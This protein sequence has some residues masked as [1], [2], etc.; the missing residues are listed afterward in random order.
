MLNAEL[1]VFRI[2]KLGTGRKFRL[3]GSVPAL[4]IG[5]HNRS[6]VLG[7]PQVIHDVGRSSFTRT[8]KVAWVAP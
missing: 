2:E 1:K 5:I 4:R 8:V 3:P 6:Q 7:L